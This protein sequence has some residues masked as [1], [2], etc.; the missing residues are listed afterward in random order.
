MTHYSKMGTLKKNI[1]DFLCVALC[2]KINGIEPARS[3]ATWPGPQ[4]R[5]GH[6]AVVNFL[7]EEGAEVNQCDCQHLNCTNW[8][9]DHLGS[10]DVVAH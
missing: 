1:P 10:T 8:S 5:F 2:P 9:L 6:S 3:V 7:L 4:A